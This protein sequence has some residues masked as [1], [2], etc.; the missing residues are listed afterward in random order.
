M[1][2]NDCS[3]RERPDCNENDIKPR[4][5]AFPGQNELNP[6]HQN[7]VTIA[8]VYEKYFQS[9]RW[10]PTF[11]YSCVTKQSTATIYQSKRTAGSGVETLVRALAQ[12]AVKENNDR[13]WSKQCV[14]DW[15]VDPRKRLALRSRTRLIPPPADA[16]FRR[17]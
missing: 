8:V 13:L 12:V 9:E 15:S 16:L 2:S 4:H 10:L 6:R 17:S 5:F 14:G 1:P 3:Q 7:Y 11:D